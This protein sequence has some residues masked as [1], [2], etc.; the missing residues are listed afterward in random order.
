[1]DPGPGSAQGLLRDQR[2]HHHADDVVHRHRP[3]QHPGQGPVP[4]SDGRHPADPDD[5]VQPDAALHPGDPGGHRRD[6]RLHRPVPGLLGAQANVLRPAPA[7]ARCESAGRIPRRYQRQAAD[8]Q[9][10]PRQ[11]RVRGYC[12]FRRHPRRVGVRSGQLESRLRGHGDPVRVPR[13]TESDRGDPVRPV[14][15]DPLQR[16]RPGGGEH[17]TSQPT[18]CS[19]SLP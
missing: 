16:R 15:R 9:L 19:S 6:H 17:A 12:S 1:M 14:L 11:R 2:D 5:P 13:A 4:G 3:R 10:I 18:S 8:H 7:C